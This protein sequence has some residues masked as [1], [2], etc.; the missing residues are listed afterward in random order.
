[1]PDF[2]GY[3]QINLGIRD[4]VR[5]SVSRNST[6]YPGIIKNTYVARYSFQK[7]PVYTV[8]SIYNWS[9]NSRVQKVKPRWRKLKSHWT[10]ESGCAEI[11]YF[12]FH[13]YSTSL[14]TILALLLSQAEPLRILRTPSRTQRTP[15]RNARS[16]APTCV[17]VCPLGISCCSAYSVQQF[18]VLNF[19]LFG[20]MQQISGCSNIYV[21]SEDLC[22]DFQ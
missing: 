17:W 10:S 19:V 7:I 9:E 12:D 22:R 18:D 11:S 21:S 2:F 8:S 13:S 1:M 4:W 16:Q 14:S 15:S 20:Y 5:D 6:S 3:P